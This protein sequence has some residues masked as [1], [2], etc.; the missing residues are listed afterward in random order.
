MPC[1]YRVEIRVENEEAAREA[2][3]AMDLARIVNVRKVGAKAY[4]VD[5]LV[6]SEESRFRQQYGKAFS[7][8]QARS[9][10]YRVAKEETL[11]DGSIKLT[12]KS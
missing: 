6:P 2:L 12:F 11:P 4:V 5:G 8:K 10:F 9:K 7:V 1:Y 3:K